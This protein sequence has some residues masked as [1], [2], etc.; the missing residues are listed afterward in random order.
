MKYENAN[1][2]YQSPSLLAQANEEI[3]EKVKEIGVIEYANWNKIKPLLEQQINSMRNWRNSWYSSSWAEIAR[4]IE[5]MRSTMTTSTQ[6]GFATP[7]SQVRGRQLNKD[8]LDPAATYAVRVCA[9]GLM[10]GLASP[11]RPWWK[12]AK[13]GRRG[14]IPDDVKK[15]LEEVEDIINVVLSTSNFY[16]SFNTECADLVTFSTAPV[17][18]YEDEIE[19]IRFY[20]PANGEYFLRTDATCRID[21]LARNFVMTVSQLISMFGYDNVGD[22]I[23]RAW[24]EKGSS[25]DKEYSVAHII[26]PNTS[27]KDSSGEFG[28]ISNIFTWREIY[29]LYGRGDKKPLSIRGFKDQP[30]TAS[31]WQ[32]VSNDPYGRGPAFDALPDVKS[33]QVETKRLHQAIEKVVNPPLLADVNLKNEPATTIP[34]GITYVANLA[35]GGGMKSIYEIRP[36]LAAMQ[37]VINDTRSRISKAFFNDLF[38]M[39]DGQNNKTMT[40]YEVA[41]RMQE[42]LQVLGPVIEGL[43]NES[44]KPKLKRILSIMDRKG[45]LPPKPKDLAQHN[46]DIEFVSMLAMAQKATATGGLERLA[47]MLGSILGAFPSVGDI[48]D[49]DE[50]I[51]TYSEL[52]GVSESILKPEDVVQ[53]IRAQKQQQQEQQQRLQAIQQGGSA[54]VQAAQGL[55][56]TQ[57]H[58]GSA[59]DALLGNSTQ[60]NG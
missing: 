5:P 31:R 15:W 33:L 27:F 39:L 42:K 60:Q 19:H 45:L 28:K 25:L 1:Y 22:D 54:A 3:G 24:D 47:Q 43:L 12:F 14:Q 41:Q 13:V 26:Q 58:T 38:L 20:N 36:D 4:F 35:N 48:I 7:N 40:A 59:L 2:Q 56:K 51:R 53:A 23:K 16:P 17:I 46:F 50:F 32:V 34:G 57:L 29:W 44:L 49:T 37:N 6:G 8:I 9:A 52:L 55:S 21:T 30:F 10:S 18:V 11:S